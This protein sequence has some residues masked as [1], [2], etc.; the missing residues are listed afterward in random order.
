MSRIAQGRRDLKMLT[1]SADS[2][3][4]SPLPLL[5]QMAIEIWQARH[6]AWEVMRRNV[7]GQY[8]QSLLGLFLA[9]VP[10]LIITIWCT[11]IRHARVIDVG[12]W[13]SRTQPSSSL[14]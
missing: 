12:T 7:S 6:L 14:A 13:I 10:P 8:R 9:F 2:R 3:L 4:Q 5:R 1:N 11:L